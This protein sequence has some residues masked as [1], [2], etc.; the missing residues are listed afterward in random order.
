MNWLY[1]QP[2]PILLMG[3]VLVAALFVGYVKTGHRALIAA[4]VLAIALVIGLLM[5]ERMVVTDR[6]QV[7][8]VL[9]TI[10]ADVER[11]DIDGA[12]RYVLPTAPG[13]EHA[14]SE[15]KRIRFEEV[16]I[17]PNLEIEL[18]PDRAPPTAEAR[19]NVVVVA[20]SPQMGFGAD[21][22]P[23]YVEV[24]FVKEGDRWMVRD[25]AHYEPT[26]GMRVEQE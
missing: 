7:E 25:Y 2:M 12:L 17:K 6:E 26:R 8:D 13:V 9:R 14:R 20:S 1:E 19:F 15:L 16:N 10:A 22:Y 3:G 23:R 4:V 11:N 24:T 5:L 18:F 21:R